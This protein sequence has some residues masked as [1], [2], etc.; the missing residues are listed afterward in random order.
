[1]FEVT[2]KAMTLETVQLGRLSQ[3][4][5][6]LVMVLRGENWFGTTDIWSFR[7]KEQKYIS[8]KGL[9]KKA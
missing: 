2:V 9:E 5:G 4:L 7:N 3:W 6:L 8:S 1:M